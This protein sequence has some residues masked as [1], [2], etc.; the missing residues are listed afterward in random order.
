MVHDGVQKGVLWSEEALH[1]RH[2]GL[3]GWNAARSYWI[4]ILSTENLEERESFTVRLTVPQCSDAG[5]YS[6][7]QSPPHPPLP[8]QNYQLFIPMKYKS[9]VSVRKEPLSAFSA[10]ASAA[11]VRCHLALACL[12]PSSPSIQMRA[13]SL[14]LC[15]FISNLSLSRLLSRSVGAYILLTLF[16]LFRFSLFIQIPAKDTE[17]TRIEKSLTIC[18]LLRIHFGRSCVIKECCDRKKGCYFF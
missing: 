10:S 8:P 1:H 9:T 17:Q 6:F 12:A 18:W 15:S 5:S 13:P 3:Y 11:R 16:L 4:P 14:F 2:L 7:C